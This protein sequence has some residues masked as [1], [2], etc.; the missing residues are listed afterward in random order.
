MAKLGLQQRSAAS[1]RGAD[2]EARQKRMDE[3]REEREREEA[4]KV[5]EQA[6]LNKMQMMAKKYGAGHSSDED[7]SEGEVSDSE[8]D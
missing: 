5:E 7:S 3:Q 6:R 8:W 4:G 1:S 2:A